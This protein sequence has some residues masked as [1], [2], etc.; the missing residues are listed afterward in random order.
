MQDRRGEHFLQV[1]LGKVRLGQVSIFQ[2]QSLAEGILSGDTIYSTG[3]VDTCQETV[4]R[5]DLR[6]HRC[7]APLT[8]GN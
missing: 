1:Y 2:W 7:S 8:R 5:T 3:P 6:A 4:G